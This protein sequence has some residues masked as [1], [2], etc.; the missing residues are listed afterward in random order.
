M[1]DQGSHVEMAVNEN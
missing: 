1:T